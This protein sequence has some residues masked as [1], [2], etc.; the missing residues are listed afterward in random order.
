MARI[1]TGVHLMLLGGTYGESDEEV[2]LV[3][4]SHL[5]EKKLIVH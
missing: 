3:S 4:A 5:K 2:M 1:T